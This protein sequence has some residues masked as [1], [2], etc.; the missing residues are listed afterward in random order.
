MNRIFGTGRGSRDSFWCIV[1]GNHVDRQG[2]RL[3]LRIS[4]AVLRGGGDGEVHQAVG[5]FRRGEDQGGLVPVA[6]VDALIA[7]R[8]GEGVA[9]RAIG[10]GRVERY[11]TDFQLERLGAILVGGVCVDGRQLD[12]MVFQAG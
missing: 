10:D 3:G 9:R 5:V 1:N 4:R 8:R 7:S 11:A 2:D 12:R 6:D